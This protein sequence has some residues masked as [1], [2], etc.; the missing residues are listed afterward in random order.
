[1]TKFIAVC[2]AT[3]RSSSDR[4]AIS[5]HD[6][7]THQARTRQNTTPDAKFSI[8]L[9]FLGLVAVPVSACFALFHPVSA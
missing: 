8:S 6:V 2:D 9:V 3:G 5:V 1:M 4:F 7:A